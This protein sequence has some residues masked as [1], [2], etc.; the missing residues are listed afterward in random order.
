MYMISYNFNISDILLHHFLLTYA[1]IFKYI[2][3]LL[4]LDYK[5]SKMSEFK[6]D[7]ENYILVLGLKLYVVEILTHNSNHILLCFI[8]N[9]II[10]L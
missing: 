1:R 7:K 3:I 5:L 6:M 8:F 9:F 2:Y 10:Y 4:D